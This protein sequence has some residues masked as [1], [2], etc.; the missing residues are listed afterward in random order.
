M[1]EILSA[2]TLKSTKVGNIEEAKNIIKKLMAAEKD[3]TKTSKPNAAKLK[4]WQTAIKAYEQTETKARALHAKITNAHPDLLN[5]KDV[6]NV[7]I[8]EMQ[9]AL[10]KLDPEKRNAILSGSGIDEIQDVKLNND[11]FENG[12]FLSNLGGDFLKGGDKSVAV[13]KAF[14]GVAIASFA[15]SGIASVFKAATGKALTGALLKDGAMTALNFLGKNILLPIWNFN[16]VG[17]ALIAAVVAMKVIPVV[18]R[19]VNKMKNKYAALTRASTMKNKLAELAEQDGP[20][21]EFENEYT[22]HSEHH[23]KH[24]QAPD[25]SGRKV[26]GNG[27]NPPSNHSSAPTTLRERLNSAKT[28][29]ERESILKSASIEEYVQ[30][31]QEI[32]DE[33][34]KDILGTERTV[35]N[36][37]SQYSSADDA[38]Q[39][40]IAGDLKEYSEK[41]GNNLK[42][43]EDALRSLDNILKTFSSNDIAYSAQNTA[44]A[45]LIE[46]RGKVNAIKDACKNKTAIKDPSLKETKKT[47]F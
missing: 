33:C 21:V 22:E 7:T 28:K 9:A 14:T 39:K 3:Q 6:L 41:A 2:E 1:A 35:N 13:S 17:T 19:F 29:K 32:I 15:A 47:I 12:G 43:A 8:N 20:S 38:R 27:K 30:Y 26:S 25:E 34:E 37:V 31:Q 5:G 10:A 18:A 23:D 16:P 36:L 40:A 44:A 4:K 46:L 45:K 42:I 11:L 24:T